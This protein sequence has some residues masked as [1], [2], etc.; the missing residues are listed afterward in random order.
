MTTIEFQAKASLKIDLRSLKEREKLFKVVAEMI[1]SAIK[2][3]H[4]YKATE[5]IS[6]SRLQ[7]WPIVIRFTSKESRKRFE[8]VISEAIHPDLLESIGI[9]HMKPVGSLNSHVRMVMC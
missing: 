3:Q 5:G 2:N 9:T 1:R 4:G 7:S 6:D 8:Q